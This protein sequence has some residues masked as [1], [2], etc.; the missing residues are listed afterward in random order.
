MSMLTNLTLSNCGKNVLNVVENAQKIPFKKGISF[1]WHSTMNAMGWVHVSDTQH[2]VNFEDDPL[3]S[4][5]DECLKNEIN[6]LYLHDFRNN[7]H[8]LKSAHNV[9]FQNNNWFTIMILS[10]RTDRSGQTV[11]PR[12]EQSD[13]GLHC[14]QFRLHLLGALLFGKA[15]LFKF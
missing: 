10:F 12:E 15:I 4:Y 5:F 9:T 14:L 8:Q 7:F 2:H 6:L 11:R 3:R 13:Q 1:F